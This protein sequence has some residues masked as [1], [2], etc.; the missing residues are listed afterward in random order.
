MTKKPDG[1]AATGGKLEK[2]DAAIEYI[3]TIKLP[4]GEYVINGELKSVPHD[5]ILKTAHA[6]RL[7]GGGCIC[8]GSGMCCFVTPTPPATEKDEK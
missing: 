5:F 7:R 8:D 6:D 3:E 1:G 2:L 4:A